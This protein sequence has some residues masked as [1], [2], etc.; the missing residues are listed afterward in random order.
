MSE[1]VPAGLPPAPDPS[2]LP[3]NDPRRKLAAAFG[4]PTEAGAQPAQQPQPMPRDVA[5]A[6]PL[7]QPLAHPALTQRDP[8]AAAPDPLSRP[9]VIPSGG[10]G[11]DNH[12]GTVLIIPMRGEQEEVIA[13]AGSGL[14]ASPALRHVVQ[15]C[16]DTRGVPYERLLL[17]DWTA[18]LLHILAYSMGADLVPLYPV[19]PH[20]EAQFD[21]SRP[22]SMIPCRVLRRPAAGEALTW[23]PASSQDEDEDIRILREMGLDDNGRDDAEQTYMA[24]GLQ[25]PIEVQLSNGQRVGWRYLRL[26]DMIQA[27]DYAR[28]AQDMNPSSAKTPG[29]RLHSF[30]MARYIATLDGRNVGA[31]EGMRWVKQA[32]LFLINELRKAIERRSFG[33]EL[34]PTFHCPNGHGFRQQLP[35]NGAMFRDRNSP[36]VS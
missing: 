22:L 5:T 36:P 25:E 10:L 30:I 21:G 11:Y 19:C 15:Q 17:E 27:E 1:Q 26:G 23:P 14:A 28:R 2:T 33:Y 6:G 3:P 18:I 35:L 32:P 16:L 34:V 20:C 29:A 31:L 24:S 9:Y 4:V 8:S 12:D 7:M 13:G